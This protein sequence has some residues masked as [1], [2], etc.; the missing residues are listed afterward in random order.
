MDASLVEMVFSFGVVLALAIWQFWTVRDAGRK[1][2]DTGK[3]S[4]PEER[5]VESPD[6]HRDEPEF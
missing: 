6:K 5:I 1:E 4:Q 3:D 2:S